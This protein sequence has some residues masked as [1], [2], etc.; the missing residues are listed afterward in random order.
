M[1]SRWALFD[2]IDNIASPR[3]LVSHILFR[4][5]GGA[6]ILTRSV[7]PLH[8]QLAVTEAFPEMLAPRL[9]E[10]GVP[11]NYAHWQRRRLAE[12]LRAAKTSTELWNHLITIVIF[13]RGADARDLA[14]TLESLHRQTYRNVEVLIAGASEPPPGLG[15]FTGHRGLFVEP[16][17]D[18][19]DLLNSPAA[20]RLWRASHLTFARAG[21]EFDSDAFAVINA[22]LNPVPG[23]PAPDLIVCD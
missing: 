8:D 12:R 21:T 23:K 20:D 4:M 2:E 1:I 15:D 7:R 22:A 3:K 9:G 18:P 19:L 17:L 14:S 5:K 10:E 6:D 11:A 16:A 13:A